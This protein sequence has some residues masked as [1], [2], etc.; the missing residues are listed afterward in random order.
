[1]KNM[2]MALAKNGLNRQKGRVL[3]LVTTALKCFKK[4]FLLK[5]Y[6]FTTVNEQRLR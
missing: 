3:N 5:K 2:L 1:M 6:T 4:E